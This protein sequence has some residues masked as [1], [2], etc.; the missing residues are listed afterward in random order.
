MANEPNPNVIANESTPLIPDEPVVHPGA[1]DHGTFSPRA[2]SPIVE[3]IHGHGHGI[4]G[5]L[6][7][8]SS[9]IDMYSAPSGGSDD[10][11]AWLKS[12]MKTT[13]MGQ[14]RELAERAGVNDTTLM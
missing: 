3:S 4:G 6:G 13:K 14:S 10:W 5:V 9:P 8:G 2:S 7:D 1:C 12:K 11:K